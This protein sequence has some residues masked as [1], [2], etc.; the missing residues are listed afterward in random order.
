[1]GAALL[2]HRGVIGRLFDVLDMSSYESSTLGSNIVII[3][4][5]PFPALVLLFLVE[6]R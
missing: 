1:M 4:T 3:M 2:S 5:Q 6:P